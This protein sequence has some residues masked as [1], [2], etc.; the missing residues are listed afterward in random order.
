MGGSLKVVRRGLAAR[1]VAAALLTSRGAHGGGLIGVVEMGGWEVARDWRREL[2]L[3]PW[4]WIG[5]NCKGKGAQIEG[6][7]RGQELHGGLGLAWLMATVSDV[8]LEDRRWWLIDYW[9]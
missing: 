7:A 2:G 6:A 9:Q 4:L 5:D 8:G 1:R 3:M